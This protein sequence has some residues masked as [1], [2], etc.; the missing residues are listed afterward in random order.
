MLLHTLCQAFLHYKLQGR[1]LLKIFVSHFSDIYKEE[2]AYLTGFLRY[3]NRV[4]SKA[5]PGD[6]LVRKRKGSYYYSISRTCPHT[7]QTSE[8]YI[9]KED[10]L[11]SAHILK[12]P[13][14]A[15]VISCTR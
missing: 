5:P 8:Q 15:R 6:M 10:P 11:L 2:E 4:L 7:G 13:D 14:A 12:Y 9:R 1:F 3:I